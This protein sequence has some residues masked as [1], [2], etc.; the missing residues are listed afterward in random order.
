[1]GWDSL[2]TAL[3]GA[4]GRRPPS[5]SLLHLVL[6]LVVEAEP[7]GLPQPVHNAEALPL[8]LQVGGC[9]V[10]VVLLLLVMLVGMWGVWYCWW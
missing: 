5:A 4:C 2:A 9:R 6:A 3:A 7:A 1:V 8:F 10:V